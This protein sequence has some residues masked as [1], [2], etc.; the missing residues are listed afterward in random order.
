MV[1]KSTINIIVDFTT[2]VKYQII[3]YNKNGDFL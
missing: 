1:T 3:I 2:I